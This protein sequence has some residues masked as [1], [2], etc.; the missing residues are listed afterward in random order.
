M[1][2]EFIQPFWINYL[3]VIVQKKKHVPRGLCYRTI[4]EVLKI[5]FARHR[6]DFNPFLHGQTREVGLCSFIFASVVTYND[7]NVTVR[8]T[9]KNARNTIREQFNAIFRGDDN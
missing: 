4:I 6:E 1:G 5:K 9:A 7:L 8:S 2:D 3:D